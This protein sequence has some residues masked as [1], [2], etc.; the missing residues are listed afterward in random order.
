MVA[1][2]VKTKDTVVSVGRASKETEQFESDVQR[3]VH[4]IRVTGEA[5]RRIAAEVAGEGYTLP[6]SGRTL[7]D[8]L[9]MPPRERKY[10]IDQLH[11]AGGNSL[12]VAQFKTGKTTLQL[13]LMKALADR[14]PFLGHFEVAPLEGRVGFWN[15]EL[16][17]DMFRE[18]GRDIG[19]VHPE[20]VAEPFHLRGASL[21]LW[22]KP[23][24]DEVVEWLRTNEVQ[25][26]I[27]DPAAEAW[28]GLVDTENDNTGIGQFCH[29]LDEVKRRAGVTDLV[30]STHM[31][32]VQPDEDNEHS[33]GATRLEDWM[34]AG[35]YLRKETK[36]ETRTLRARGRDVELEALDLTYNHGTRRLAFSGQTRDK[37]RAQEGTQ[38]VVDALAELERNG[39]H[40][41]KSTN[42]LTAAMSGDKT[43]HSEWVQAA[44]KE[45]Y[46]MRSQNGKG[47]SCELTDKGRDLASRRVTGNKAP[48]AG[49]APLKV[50]R[51]R[52]GGTRK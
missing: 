33:R 1:I 15:Y 36:S 30:L 19:I 5:Q 18:W 4:N 35:W 37:R 42:A 16:D 49:R 51:K 20:R 43:H 41:A 12:L 29:V 40:P 6:A 2:K 31:G 17:A 28:N 34:D 22:L 25:F 10:T 24:Q 26:L 8:D 3:H 48:P 23:V 32:R 46:I 47:L 21:P 50:Q 13:N 39:Q 14:E 45:G 27:I 44:E 52:R 7:A 9:A 38:V 11:T